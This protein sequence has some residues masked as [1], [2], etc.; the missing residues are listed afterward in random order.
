MYRPDAA[1]KFPALVLR[2]P[3]DA[4]RDDANLEFNRKAAKEG[5]LVFLVDVRGRY[6][7]EG[8]FEAYR[9]EKQDGYDVIEWIGQSEY[10]NG[11]VG[12]YGISYRGYSQWLAMAQNPPHL[13]AASPANTPI[14]SHDFFYWGGAFSTAWL[15]WFMPSIFANKRMRAGDTSGPWDGAIAREQWH[16]SDKKKWYSYRPLYDLPILKVHGP[17]YYQWMVHPEKSAWWDFASIE[18]DFNKISVPAFLISG[19]YDAAYGPEGAT[20]GFKK[21]KTETASKNAR[22][23]TRLILG[24]WNHTWVT[25]AKTTFGEVNFGPS[26]GFDYDTE[27]LR[28]FNKTLKGI[29]YDFPPVSIFV[30]GENKWRDETEWPLSRAV[31]TSFYFHS[32]GRAVNDKTDGVLNG[33]KP[34]KEPGDS[35]V[36][37]PSDPYWDISYLNSFPFDQRDNENRKDVLV[38]TSAPLEADLEVT[39]EMVAELFVS[40]TGKDTDFTF[41]VTDVYPDGRSINVAGLD[42]GYL[43]MRY[44]D[45]FESQSLITPGQIYKITIGGLYT[46]NLFKKGHR[47]RVQI[48]S[49]KAPHYDANPNTGTAIAT[50]KTLKSVTNSIFHSETTPSRLVLPIIP[51]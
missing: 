27:L 37:D 35:Y 24:P 19:W 42:A 5:Y 16:Q 12:T 40:S 50:E 38:Y 39:G 51:R 9:N 34:G 43:R 15:D 3:Y 18:N 32:S 47:I 8:E 17:E 31:A 26:A 20:K 10:C 6:T 23:N 22:E 11:K 45:G 49:S 41:S 2:T 1:G 14:T 4:S 29:D 36:F 25:T 13:A 28:W 33:Q 30:M 21:M 48:T 7:S 46:S 44:R